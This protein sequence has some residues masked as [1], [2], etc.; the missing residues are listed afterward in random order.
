MKEKGDRKDDMTKPPVSIAGSASMKADCRKTR[1]MPNLEK[2]IYIS[3]D[4]IERP[5]PLE[6]SY[7]LEATPVNLTGVILF[8]LVICAASL[9]VDD[10]FFKL[11]HHHLLSSFGCV[12][13]SNA[14][15]S[16]MESYGDWGISDRQESSLQRQ[17]MM[18]I[19]DH[20]PVPGMPGEANSELVNVIVTTRTI[21]ESHALVHGGVFVM[22]IMI[23]LIWSLSAYIAFTQMRSVV[24][25]NSY[26]I[27]LSPRSPKGW[28]R[29]FQTVGTPTATSPT[30]TSCSA[31]REY[32]ILHPPEAFEEV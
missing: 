8:T 1:R 11:N 14:D 20:E 21:R 26:S 30:T 19:L 16:H 13:D 9:I 23:L 4:S 24:R 5:E 10:L 32:R 7:D 27:L 31:A 3:V 22:L 28:A 2:R 15:S 18:P 6:L 29:S 17:L 25:Q 12:S